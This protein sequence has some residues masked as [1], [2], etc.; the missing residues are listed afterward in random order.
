MGGA[1]PALP[2]ELTV[3]TVFAI[4]VNNA[5]PIMGAAR[6]TWVRGQRGRSQRYGW[7]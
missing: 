2:R 3:S 7:K 6:A 4:A 5:A 1:N